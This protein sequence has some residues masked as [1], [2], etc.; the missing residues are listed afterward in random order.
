MADLGYVLAK[1]HGIHSKS[2]NGETLARYSKIDS[3]DKLEKALFAGEAAD[4]PTKQ[5][6]TRVE[7][8]FRDKIIGQITDITNYLGNDNRLINSFLMRY[9][10]ENVKRIVR[11][12]INGENTIPTLT[13]LNIPNGLDYALIAKTNF[14]EQNAL[15][16]VLS[17]TVFSFVI[18]IAK[19]KNVSATDIALDK[20]YYTNLISAAKTLPKEQ[21]ET[22]LGII[23]DEINLTNIIWM[24]R[25]IRY[26]KMDDEQIKSMLITAE[27]VLTAEELLPMMNTDSTKE[28]KVIRKYRSIFENVF[29]NDNTDITKADKSAE[30]YIN[31]RYR[32]MFTEEYNILTVIAYIY[33]KMQEY[34]DIVQI[35]ETLRYKA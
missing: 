33:I 3:I 30:Q 29:V 12:V 21:K 35:V 24:M 14:T 18:D 7:E 31:H 5:I 17:N 23:T 8:R 26:Y 34:S 20:F 13:K 11:A 22:L 10:I 27:G 32:K 2:V 25:L 28:S 15:Q 1:I 6:Y 19:N 4:T 16:N 9:E